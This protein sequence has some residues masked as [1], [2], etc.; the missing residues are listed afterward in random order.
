MR[1]ARIGNTDSFIALTEHML[2]SFKRND[3][4][5]FLS[6]LLFKAWPW[7]LKV[8]PHHGRTIVRITQEELTEVQS[9]WSEGPHH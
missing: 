6:H 9:L 3:I 2:W 4:I 7:Q 8:V 1:R 5:V